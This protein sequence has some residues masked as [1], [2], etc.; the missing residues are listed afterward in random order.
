MR[1]GAAWL[2]LCHQCCM[3]YLRGCE[4]GVDCGSDGNWL[5]LWKGER[6]VDSAFG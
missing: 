5:A 1:N 4:K 2:D 6:L 3:S